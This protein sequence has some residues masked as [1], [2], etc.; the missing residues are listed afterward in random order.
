MKLFAIG[1]CVSSFSSLFSLFVVKLAA[2]G[3]CVSSLSSLFSLLVV[4]LSAIGECVSSLSSLFTLRVAFNR[5]DTSSNAVRNPCIAA[6]D[7]KT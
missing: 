2:I 5:S 3:E 7:E 4:K 1:E 6:R